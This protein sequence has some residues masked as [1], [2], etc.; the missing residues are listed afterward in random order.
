MP[1]ETAIGACYVIRASTKIAGVTS[2]RTGV[3]FS[4]RWPA[5]SHWTAAGW[6]RSL[7]DYHQVGVEQSD[8]PQPAVVSPWV[9]LG[10]VPNTTRPDKRLT[11]PTGTRLDFI[12]QL[13]ITAESSKREITLH[14]RG[15]IKKSAQCILGHNPGDWRSWQSNDWSYR[16]FAVPT[17]LKVSYVQLYVIPF[18]TAATQTDN[19]SNGNSKW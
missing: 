4:L 13:T 19:N 1:P 3:F 15:G 2:F 9:S 12:E 10:L 5:E 17:L 7:T 14:W 16:I 8:S 18:I 11:W 6:T